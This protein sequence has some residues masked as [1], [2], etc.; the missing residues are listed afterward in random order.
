MEDRVEAALFYAR[1]AIKSSSR[2]E[3]ALHELADLHRGGANEA[4]WLDLWQDSIRLYARIDKALKPDPGEPPI[5][6]EFE[7]EDPTTQT[8]PTLT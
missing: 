4:L 8:L 7:A 3:H 5:F 2:L 6:S 1:R